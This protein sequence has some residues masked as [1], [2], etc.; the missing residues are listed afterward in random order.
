MKHVSVYSGGKHRVSNLHLKTQG[1]YPVCSGGGGGAQNITY[2]RA[3]HERDSAKG[4]FI[5]RVP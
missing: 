4:H 1:A 5:G 3:H 2:A